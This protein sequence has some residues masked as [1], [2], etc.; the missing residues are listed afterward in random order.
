MAKTLKGRIV[1]IAATGAVPEAQ[2]SDLTL[3]GFQGLNWVQVNNCGALG[4]SGSSTNLPTYDEFDTAVIQK[5]KGITDAGSTT[6]EVSLNLTDDGQNAM[7]AAALEPDDYAISWVDDDNVTHYQR[8]KITG[9]TAPNGR[10][11]DFRRQVFTMGFNQRE[12]I[13]VA[14]DFVAPANTLAPAI[15]GPTTA[16]DVSAASVLTCIEGEWDG[17]PY[18]FE[19]QWQQDTAGNGTFANIGGQ[20]SRTLT[21]VVGYQGNCLR[22]GVKGVGPGGTTASFAFSTPTLI[23]IA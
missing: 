6:L 16:P 2:N 19:Y 1:Y 15:S 14:A 7:R 5:G 12:V 8:G 13:A 18:S 23:V 20:T 17:H 21:T 10:N 3:S 9:P 4:E 11:E 22:V